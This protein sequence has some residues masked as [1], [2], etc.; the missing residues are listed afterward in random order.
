[1]CNW[2]CRKCCRLTSR[3]A[4]G[5]GDLRVQCCENRERRRGEEREREERKKKRSFFSSN[6]LVVQRLQSRTCV[7]PKDQLKE[8][9]YHKRRTSRP[10]PARSTY[11]NLDKIRQSDTQNTQ[12]T[13]F[14]SLTSRERRQSMYFFHI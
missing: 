8:F 13:I 4:R 3:G 9:I 7:F 14:H 6:R 12:I 1:M 10:N 5:L 2:R 11:F